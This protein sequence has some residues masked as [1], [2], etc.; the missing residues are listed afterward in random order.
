MTTSLIFKTLIN[1][2][3]VSP[4][5]EVTVYLSYVSTPKVARMKD[6]E[7]SADEPFAFEAREFLRKLLIGKEVE[8][9]EDYRLS[10]NNV[11]AAT[12]YL[13]DD[14][15]SINLK[16]VKAGLSE[17][18][19][20]KP[21]PD[22][23]EM[24]ILQEAE[25]EAKAQG[26]GRWS[27]EPAKIVREQILNELTKETAEKLLNQT[28]TG[29]VEHVKDGSSF[30]IG[31]FLPLNKP[32]E[33]RTIYQL[34]SLNLSG[35]KCPS[36]IDEFGDEAKFF[37][38]SRLLNREVDVSIEQV[39]ALNFVSLVGTITFNKK[40]IALFLLKEGLARIVDRT[41]SGVPGIPQYREAERSA[42]ESKLRL[43]ENYEAPVVRSNESK[44][45]FESE[46]VEIVNSECIIVER[47]SD[48]ELCK[49]WFSSIRGPKADSSKYNANN[50]IRPLYDIPLAFDTREFLRKK[51][52]G[53]SVLVKI[54]Y[55][56]PKTDQFPEKTFATVF[57][58]EVNVQ[59]ALVLKGFAT[60]VKRND[61]DQ[62]SC[63]FDE[64]LEAESKAQKTNKGLFAKNVKAKPI[65]PIDVSGDANRAQL[66]L[67]TL[68]RGAP[69]DAIIEYIFS[70]SKLK[71]YL[72]KENLLINF[73][74][75]GIQVEKN[76]ND[77]SMRIVKRLVHQRDVKLVFERVDK[78]GNFIGTLKFE[79][80][81]VG[82]VSLAYYLVKEGLCKIRDEKDGQLLTAQNDA[83]QNKRGIWL[84]YVDEEPAPDEE[85]NGKENEFENG[86]DDEKKDFVDVVEAKGLKKGVVSIIS[87]DALTVYM[88]KV[89]HGLALDELIANLR[90]DLASNPPLPGAYRP[91]P[92]DYCAA[93]FSEDGLWYRARV[94][95]VNLSEKTVDVS[96]IDYG[97]KAVVK[98][99]NE[100]AALPN[101]SYG[102]TALP[103]V[104]QLY[105][106][107]YVYL[108]KNDQ[109]AVEEARAELELRLNKEL[110]IKPEYR[111]QNGQDQITLLDPETKEDVI[112]NMVKEGFYCVEK[113]NV[114]G[115][116]KK[117]T[118]KQYK[119]Y[120]EAMEK[121]LSERLN[122]W[123]YG[124]AILVSDQKKVLNSI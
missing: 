82:P 122:L 104:A 86:V 97:N 39:Q 66:Q 42:K 40:N 98:M 28:V 100:V 117:L 81:G 120:K 103:A 10:S 26:I 101:S 78:A 105:G 48:K 25:V 83:Q 112:L 64:L 46:V 106:L 20:K 29:I 5:V 123:R 90:E 74:V 15:E 9:R 119:K 50:K 124:F 99:A 87:N 60:V 54:D 79:L 35:I 68:S 24:K 41:L 11:I 76:K 118:E 19:R 14:K 13:K 53:K 16:L 34:I 65:K 70:L 121:A 51:L 91:K 109:D 7:Y 52:I 94:D 75:S 67:D 6:G 72:P 37:S 4:T 102:I 21:L 18:N 77:E 71:C 8:Y 96:Y 23:E 30:K 84:N 36:T 17:I 56:Q 57:L 85:E 31:V 58:G 1:L 3:L 95:K 92:G 61:E 45:Q 111:L 44:R 88:Q 33:Q 116:N 107:G 27:S 114:Y 63:A 108:P 59:V 38:E 12:V 32:K 113:R 73:V 62:K 110:L 47:K 80:D 49:I 115:K 43:W 69:K 93:I 2:S 89:E 22:T 55:E